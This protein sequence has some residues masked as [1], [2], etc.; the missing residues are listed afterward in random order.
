MTLAISSGADVMLALGEF[1][2]SV[3]TAAYQELTRTTEQRWQA[4]DRFG[5]LATLQ[6]TGPGTETITLPGVIFPQYRG[7]LG[8]VDRMRRIAARAV[9]LALI[10]GAGRIL[11]RYVIE[12]VEE[13]QSVFAAAGIARKIEF[14]LNLRLYDGP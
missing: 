6:H 11:G 13:R 5:K 9:P 14:T 3:N 12:R 8:Q 10:T 2:F 4:Q 7:G 1:Q